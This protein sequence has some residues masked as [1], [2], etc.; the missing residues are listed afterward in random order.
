MGLFIAMETF[1]SLPLA[2]VRQIINYKIDLQLLQMKWSK[3]IWRR[4]TVRWNWTAA[5]TRSST[6]ETYW[7][8]RT[9]KSRRCSL[10]TA[11]FWWEFDELTPHNRTVC[12]NNCRYISTF[13]NCSVFYVHA[14][15]NPTNAGTTELKKFASHLVTQQI[16]LSLNS[17]MTYS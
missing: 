13:I 2:K 1:K 16:K 11:V 7:I 12:F 3:C 8:W 5:V 17:Y 4:F 10:T 15:H 9:T 6:R 14:A